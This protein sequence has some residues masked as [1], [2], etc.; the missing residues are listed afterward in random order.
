VLF[1]RSGETGTVLV[2]PDGFDDA[3]RERV[4]AF[5]IARGFEVDA[6]PDAEG[7]PPEHDALVRPIYEHALQA[8][9]AGPRHAAIF[10]E[11]YDLDIAPATDDRPYFGS[12][13]RSAPGVATLRAGIGANDGAEGAMLAAVARSATVAI[14][15]LLAP[16][17]VLVRRRAPAQLPEV[18]RTAAYF[19]A[20]G[21][22]FMF[23]EIAALQRLSLV[24]GHPV[25]ATAL[26]VAAILAFSGIGSAVSDRLPARAASA[27]VAVAAIAAVAALALPWT[28][29]VTALPFAGRA[30]AA[31][32]LVAIPGVLLGGPFPLGLRRLAHGADGIAWAWAASGFAAVVASSLAAL[33]AM[34]A[35]GR[36]LIAAGAACYLLAALIARPHHP[37]RP[38]TP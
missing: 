29:V 16:L 18:G 20:I 15:L 26:T 6:P 30:A 34:A 9:V 22:G 23:V 2:K 17:L 38:L 10:A 14:V 21:F 4:R 35:G 28:E 27:C 1:V 3:E 37:P 7:L 33:I 25:Y 11:R 12:F 5:A 32:A 19:G 24:L 8:I 13:R 36:I 31:L